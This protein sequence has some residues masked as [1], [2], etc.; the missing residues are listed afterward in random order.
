MPSNIPRRTVAK[1]TVRI[2]TTNFIQHHVGRNAAALAY[3]LLFAIFPLLIFISNL[4]GMLDLDTAAITRVL[5]RVMPTNAVELLESY[6][7]YVA[8][9]SSGVMLTFS[10][11][12]T[13]YFPYRAVKGLMDDV[14]LAYQLGRPEKP[15]R[16]AIRELVYTVIF[17][18]LIIVTLLLS[19]LGQQVIRTVTQYLPPAPEFV[20]TLWQYLRFLLAAAVMFVALGML[21][22][23][24]QDQRQP[25]SATLPGA[26]MA[27][28]G[29][30]IVSIGF[31][32][33][34]EN[35][36]DYT[37]IYGTLGAVIV[38][39]LWLYMTAVML[40]FGAEFNAALRQA[41]NQN[42]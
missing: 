5:E 41:K 22:G 3:Y 29:W 35:F 38:L 19:F 13:L 2:L 12:F 40:I 16:Y 24:A 8:A 6:L 23:A 26:V 31:S 7:D 4:L 11:V 37:L 20:L 28:V 32:F 15:V 34:V 17:L 21:Y 39:L 1:R 33:Y 18:V 42:D 30:L 14:R 9:N 25:V 27:M 10:L 36:S